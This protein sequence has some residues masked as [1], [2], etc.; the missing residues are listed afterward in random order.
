ME[1]LADLS[2]LYP[3]MR[4][5]QLVEMVALLS[6]EDSPRGAVDTDDDRLLEAA[7]DHLRVRRE[8]LEGEDGP[9]PDRPLPESRA[10]LLNLLRQEGHR[11]DR[12]FGRLV[13]R[14][15]ASSGVGLY[16]AE[17]EQLVAAARRLG[18]G[19]GG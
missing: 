11:R 18:I 4:F 1:T 10:E 8:Q 13:G 6:S 9:M 2:H 19:Q 7:K 16:D 3:E 12:F 15:A 14:L 17:D 5:G